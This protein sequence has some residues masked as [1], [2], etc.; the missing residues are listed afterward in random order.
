MVDFAVFGADIRVNASINGPSSGGTNN[1]GTAT[2]SGGSSVFDAD[3]VVLFS[4]VGTTG[5]D[6]I[7]ANS[8]IADVTVFETLAD[9]Q[10][11]LVSGDTDLIK[12]DYKPQNPGQTGTV[13]G[14]L[15][16]HGDGYFKFNSN[17][18]VP[19]GGA[20]GNGPSLGNTMTIAPGTG[21]G[22]SSANVVLD[23]SQD[24]DFDN[25]GMID[26]GTVEE[27]NNDFLAGSD[28]A[29]CF[30]RGTLI[31]TDTGEIAVE[32]LTPG[33]LVRTRDN[34]FQPIR[35]VGMSLTRDRA[36]RIKAGAMGNA[37]DLVVSPRHRMVLEGWR[38]ELLFDHGHVL[39]PAMQ[40]VNEKTILRD[41]MA[42]VEYF[43]VMFDA[44]EIIFAEGSATESFHPDQPSMGAMDQAAREEIFT[45]FPELRDGADRTE[46]AASLSASE[47]AYVT[48][49]LDAILT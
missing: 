1:Q 15:S 44:H 36:V 25:S 49:H 47:A 22:T 42:E 12:H 43:H 8:A 30:C 26:A 33:T 35:W 23:R 18:I 11:F 5:S 34:G 46:A 14:G 27:G 29:L 24:I 2:I 40:L 3:D 6:E 37:R 9:Y 17:V 38:L 39:V 16:G 10:E 41:E 28:W 7:T 13:Q 21:I 4:A 32:D 31:E 20:D 45:L 48:R 19:D